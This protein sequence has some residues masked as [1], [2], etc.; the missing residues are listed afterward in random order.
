[1][2]KGVKNCYKCYIIINYILNKY[3]YNFKNNK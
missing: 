1:M 2:R 3:E